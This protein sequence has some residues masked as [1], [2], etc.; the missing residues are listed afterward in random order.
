[1]GIHDDF[2]DSVITHPEWES[3]RKDVDNETFGSLCWYVNNGPGYCAEAPSHIRAL[4][5]RLDVDLGA[6]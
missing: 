6:W 4:L 2:I 5:N 3:I 1:M